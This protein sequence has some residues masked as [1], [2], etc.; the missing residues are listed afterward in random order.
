MHSR[1]KRWPQGRVRI[2]SPPWKST[3]HTPHVLNIVLLLPEEP[4]SSDTQ[5]EAPSSSSA[6]MGSFQNATP[7]QCVSAAGALVVEGSCE[8]LSLKFKEDESG[9][10]TTGLSGGWYVLISKRAKSSESKVFG[11]KDSSSLPN[12]S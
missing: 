9:S 2:S 4:S 12:K 8:M 10:E 7:K 5:V 3:R 1:W 6:G 11:F